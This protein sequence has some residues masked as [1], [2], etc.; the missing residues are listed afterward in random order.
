[1][2]YSQGGKRKDVLSLRGRPGKGKDRLRKKT[3][4]LQTNRA[5][6]KGG[7]KRGDDVPDSPIARGKDGTYL[8]R[9]LRGKRSKQILPEEKGERKRIFRPS[10]GGEGLSGELGGGRKEVRRGT[11]PS[12]RGNRHGR[13]KK[14]S[15]TGEG[16]EPY[17]KKERREKNSLPGKKEE[18]R[19]AFS[20]YSR[21]RSKPGETEER[22]GRRGGETG[23]LFSLSKGR[24]NLETKK[25]RGGGVFLKRRGKKGG[26]KC[27]F[28]SGRGSY[29]GAEKRENRYI[30]LFLQIQREKKRGD[31]LSTLPLQK[32]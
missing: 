13:G 17:P 20:Y 32:E 16:K 14:R 21:E 27:S 15:I 19:R 18:G 22:K 2:L 8:R 25:E 1:M 29:T 6:K 26:K 4:R 5:G 28:L 12:P 7:R 24:G 11:F 3:V 23:N 30:H 10:R 9:R 31:A